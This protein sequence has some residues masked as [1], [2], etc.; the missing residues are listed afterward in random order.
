[1]Q[2]AQVRTF[3]ENCGH[4][5]KYN[6]DF[7]KKLGLF[8]LLSFLL[9]SWRDI[10][11]SRGDGMKLFG[12]FEAVKFYEENLIFITH[13]RFLYYIY[14][15]K[16]NCWRKYRNAGND[17]ITIQNY[18]DVSKEEL[19]DAMQGVYPTKE[20]DFMRLCNSK[21][22][23]IRDMIDLLEDDFSVYMSGPIYGKVHQIL[24]QSD[25]CHKAFEKI[26]MLLTNGTLCNKTEEQV[27]V[28]IENLSFSMLGRNIFKN[29][30]GIVD[31]HYGSSYFWISPV[32]VIDFSNTN[33]SDNVARN[34]GIEISIEEDDVYTY[35]TPFLYKYFEDKLEANK[36]RIEYQWIDDDGNEQVSV[37]KGF[38]WY[39]THNFFSFAS[40]E[41]IIQEIAN[42][43]DILTSG[44][45]NE[46]TEKLKDT[47]IELVIDFYKRFIYRME[48]MMKVGIEKGY[49]LISFMGP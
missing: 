24:L 3:Y 41:K 47:E 23:W 21:Q 18:D 31:G 28:E 49:D 11:Q 48:Y 13:N 34:R 27:L 4:L 2:K 9:D 1:M 42:T 39:L 43:I 20:T 37:I 16:H 8:C 36:K 10:I 15:Y 33:S 40:M 5:P 7:D 32:R 38:E 46:F 12:D 19:I 6:P 44:K 14:N 17:S 22:L 30:I 29:E 25:I 35:L 26:K 45:K